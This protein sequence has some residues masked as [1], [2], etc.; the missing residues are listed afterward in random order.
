MPNTKYIVTHPK[1]GE[2]Q[3]NLSVSIE[4]FKELLATGK[5]MLTLFWANGSY[6]GVFDPEYLD[7]CTITGADE[8]K[9]E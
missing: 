7:E 8:N 5:D 1:D 2:Y 4:K 9:S 3:L 6:A